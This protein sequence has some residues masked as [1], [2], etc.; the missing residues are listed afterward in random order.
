M[1]FLTASLAYSPLAARV[2]SNAPSTTE[3][4][5][6]VEGTHPELN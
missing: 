5:A 6:G 2:L 4:K 3:T 1:S